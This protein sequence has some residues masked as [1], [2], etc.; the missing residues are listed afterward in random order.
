MHLWTFGTSLNLTCTAR[1]NENYEWKNDYIKPNEITWFNS[2]EQVVGQCKMQKA[3]VMNCTLFLGAF[4]KRKLNDSY[5]CRASSD[6]HCTRKKF[7]VPIG[8][9]QALVF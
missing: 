2:S 8:K 9:Q 5:T 7:D 1:V 4:I 3:A 6:S